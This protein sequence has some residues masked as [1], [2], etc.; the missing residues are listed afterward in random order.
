M[1]E[2]GFDKGAVALAEAGVVESNAKGHCV[3]KVCVVD[4]VEHLVQL[5]LIRVYPPPWVLRL[6]TC[7]HAQRAHASTAP[8]VQAQRAGGV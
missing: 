6:R 1:L 8:R 2:E 7:L 4:L 5:L 3:P